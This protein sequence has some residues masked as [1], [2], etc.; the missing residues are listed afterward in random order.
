M[1]EEAVEGALGVTERLGDDQDLAVGECGGADPEGR[2]RRS[3]PT[4]R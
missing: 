3:A 4:V 2:V 1:S